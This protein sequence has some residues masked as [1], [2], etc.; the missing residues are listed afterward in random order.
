MGRPVWRAHVRNTRMR[1]HRHNRMPSHVTREPLG[2]IRDLIGFIE[3]RE[4]LIGQPARARARKAVCTAGCITNSPSFGFIYPVLSICLSASP[5]PLSRS[6]S[7][8]LPPP[9]CLV[10]SLSLSLS[11]SPF[12]R[13]R[14]V[15]S[16]SLSATVKVET[17]LGSNCEI[18][19][20]T[21][22]MICTV[23]VEFASQSYFC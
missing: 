21:G 10:L 8:L 13:D 12:P 6:L 17:F 1:G 22:T 4:A 23:N 16:S 3:C 11:L 19:G 15:P 7:L 20:R 9:L 18:P 5:P 14:N 2:N